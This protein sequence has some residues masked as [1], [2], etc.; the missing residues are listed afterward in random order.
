MISSIPITMRTNQ[1]TLLASFS[2]VFDRSKNSNKRECCES[3]TLQW[4]HVPLYFF[5][6]G[7]EAI[8]FSCCLL[9][10]LTRKARRYSTRKNSWFVVWIWLLNLRQVG[11]WRCQQIGNRNNYRNHT[12]GI[13][14]SLQNCKILYRN[15]PVIGCSQLSFECFPSK[16]VPT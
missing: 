3:A 9:P 1:K 16:D 15:H 4:T 14:T 12:C 2:H 10:Q 6:S 11:F 8:F 7:T 5:R 13:G